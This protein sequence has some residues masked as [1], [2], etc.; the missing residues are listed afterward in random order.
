MDS[1]SEKSC[2]GWNFYKEEL[3]DQQLRPSRT[4]IRYGNSTTQR[5]QGIVK[6]RLE[7]Q[8]RFYSALFLVVRN[9]PYKVLLGADF[10]RKYGARLKAT[11][12]KW[13]VNFSEDEEVVQLAQ[14]DESFN[15]EIS[16]EVLATVDRQPDQYWMMGR[17]ET[18]KRV[19]ND[20][21]DIDHNVL[22]EL[23]F[24][25]SGRSEEKQVPSLSEKQRKFL[26]N[27]GEREIS[28]KERYY[29]LALWDFIL[30]AQHE[31]LVDQV[32]TKVFT[33]DMAQVCGENWKRMKDWQRKCVIHLLRSYEDRFATSIHQLE[34]TTWSTFEFT[35]EKTPKA[36]KPF[37][38][39]PVEDYIMQ[40]QIE[41]YM[42]AGMLKSSQSTTPSAA[43]LVKRPK[44]GYQHMN[45]KALLKTLKKEN[46]SIDEIA[47]KLQEYYSFRLCGNYTGVNEVTKKVAT[48]L[49]VIQDLLDWL[50]GTSWYAKN[51][52]KACY[53]QIPM[54]D[55][56]RP[57][58][59]IITRHGVY[60]WTVTPFGPSNAVS[61]AQTLLERLVAD[62]TRSQGIIDDILSA[63]RSFCELLYEIIQLYQNCRKANMKMHP[64]KI[65]LFRRELSF[66]GFTVGDEGLKV[67]P[68]KIN[69]LCKF[70]KPTCKRDI[71]S[72]Q[73][74]LQFVRIFIPNLS[75]KMY[76]L[77][78]L[79]KKNVKFKWG[80]EQQK[81]F[82]VIRELLNSE[83][84]LRHP[85]F[86]RKFILFVDASDYAIGAVL[87]QEHQG[88]YYFIRFASKTLNDAQTRYS[89]TERE[90]LAVVYFVDYFRFYLFGN[91]FEIITDHGALR[92]LMKNKSLNARLSNWA[93]KLS[94]Y[95]FGIKYIQGTL[96]PADAPSRMKLEENQ[97]VLAG[98]KDRAIEMHERSDDN[99]LRG[100]TQKIPKK[101]STTRVRSAG[102]PPDRPSADDATDPE[103]VQLITGNNKVLEE[104]STTS[105]LSV[106]ESVKINRPSEEIRP[107]SIQPL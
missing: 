69:K 85:D 50:H 80:K 64:G 88:K 9:A 65:E 35:C 58:L 90:C 103:S 38:L 16:E 41:Q 42:E 31:Q 32:K 76:P 66:M 100:I 62:L 94:P 52:F 45:Y 53:M 18:G 79:L 12:E 101:R 47:D 86:S 93:T 1:A 60:E 105:N 59:A 36:Q 51:D 75:K 84:C 63:G 68:D 104:S 82:E 72:L 96:N 25:S 74:F 24:E 48:A 4:T 106:H 67:Q 34:R 29:F 83:Q 40:R 87:V 89:A 97:A 27:Q 57:L 15:H 26:I 92:Y 22:E 3:K 70:K 56:C 17:D 6:G 11:M 2:I 99:N 33:F 98:T 23:P 39:S 91:Y 30:K 43:F 73:G 5:A 77:T 21:M 10:L 28:E 102:R 8:E 13:Q 61:C 7:Y 46:R 81:A 71:K 49:P 44:E 37:R 20:P 95:Y 19:I 78:K 55:K 14:F 107:R 54:A